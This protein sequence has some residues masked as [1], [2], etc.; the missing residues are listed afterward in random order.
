MLCALIMTVQ[1]EYINPLVATFLKC[2]NILLNVSYYTGIMLDAFSD[3]LCSKLCWHN[4]LVP[5]D[6]SANGNVE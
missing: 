4:R 6:G 2:M 3:L 1:L 5:S